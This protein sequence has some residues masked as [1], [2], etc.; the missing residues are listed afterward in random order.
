M[1]YIQNL[2]ELLNYEKLNIFRDLRGSTITCSYQSVRVSVCLHVC[3]RIKISYSDRIS[4]R[5]EIVIAGNWARENIQGKSKTCQILKYYFQIKFLLRKGFKFE[6]LEGF[7]LNGLNHTYLI[8]YEFKK[9]VKN[10]GPRIC[11][12][13][14]IP[15]LS[16][17]R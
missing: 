5:G 17:V 3:D 13:D 12:A 16:T 9:V 7:F 2:K 14:I 15:V 10:I 1:P 11:L 8:I 4:T 6:I